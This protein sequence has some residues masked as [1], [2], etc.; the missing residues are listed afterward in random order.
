[1]KIRGKQKKKERGNLSFPPLPS[2]NQTPLTITF[3][4]AIWRLG[5]IPHSH[6]LNSSGLPSFSPSL[7]RH[8]N[9]TAMKLWALSLAFAFLAAPYSAVAANDCQPVTWDDT[10]QRRDFAIA[11][12][13]S[14]DSIIVPNPVIEVRQASPTPLKPGDINCR[15][16]MST[17]D[18]VNYYTCKKMANDWGVSIAGFF[19]MNPALKVD[20]S[21]IQPNTQYCIQAYIEPLRSSDGRCAPNYNNAVCSGTSSGRCCNAQTWKCGNTTADCSDG[22]CY[23]GSCAGDWVWS[24]NGTCGGSRQCPPKWGDCCNMQGKCGNGT[25]FCAENVCQS[26]KCNWPWLRNTTATTSSPTASSS[27]T[28]TSSTSSSASSP[29]VPPVPSSTDYCQGGTGAAPYTDLCSYGCWFGYCPPPCTCMTVT[30]SLQTPKKPEKRGIAQP[31]YQNLLNFNQLC[32]F[33][34]SQPN[35]FAYCPATYCKYIT[36]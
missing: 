13:G 31:A 12:G 21:N 18:D 28:R 22:T 20:C 6:H 24:T 27:A 30:N 35:P 8:S 11:T 2:L 10:P 15:A 25:T 9:T 32:D 23:E 4:A 36:Y 34:C 3:T 29:G 1:M 7:F 19:K 33:G 26:G 17:W 14:N 5:Q 16:W